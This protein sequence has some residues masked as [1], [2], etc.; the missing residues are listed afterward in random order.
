M[1]TGWRYRILSMA[2]VCVITAAAALVAN[3]RFP[4]SLFTT[5]IPVFNQ[6]S[7]TV[8]TGR[9]LA[10]A[11]GLSIGFTAM[12]LLPLYKPRPRRH[13]D[14]VI[15]T[16]KRIL[17]ASLGLATLGYFNWSHRLP[18]ATLVM[19]TVLLAV[20][21][22]L[23]FVVIRRA[24]STD[25]DRIII[26]GDDIDQ[27]RRI[28]QEVSMS[29]LG[30]LCPTTV[31]SPSSGW[32]VK[33][34]SDG[35][36]PVHN[37]ERL[38]G[39][40]RLDDTLIERDID[41][42]VLAFRHTDR[43][44]FFGALNVCYDHGVRTKVHREYADTILTS[45]NNSGPLVDVDVEP[46]DFQDY[47]LKRGFDVT[48]AVVGMIVFAP[49][50]AFIPVLIKLDSEGPVL[51]RQERTAG[52][53]GR[54]T[55]FKFRTMYP[56]GESPIPI[57]DNENDRITRVGRILRKTHL[58]ELP[59][60]WLILV[61]NMST[62]GPRPVW[63][64]E[65]T[66]LEAE[67]DVWRKRWFVKPGLTGLAQIRGAGSTSPEAKLRSDLEYIRRQSFSLDCYILFKQIWL[68]VIDIAVFLGITVE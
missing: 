53:G 46:W 16:Q 15:F 54:L 24:P 57:E 68:V 12:A 25:P 65:E 19:V 14:I 44:D 62:V 42:A 38:G 2:G 30:Y 20:A 37:L 32:Q 67:T 58:D 29:F 55:V 10:Q 33:T 7:V 27:I 23:W 5:Y 21:I 3:H 64:D 61:G 28:Y 52:L 17:V 41:T 35:G 8:L 31:S 6:L 63:T 9:D 49:L 56:Q 34:I 50:L 22:P 60:L 4:Q 18:R 39:L 13:V 26:I 40:S 51:Y 11:L 59:Q 43:E 1:K 66:L 47:L 45:E 36:N 48:F